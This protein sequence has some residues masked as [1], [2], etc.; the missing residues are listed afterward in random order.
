MTIQ[1]PAT[2]NETYFNQDYKLWPIWLGLVWW[3]AS[4]APLIV[5]AFRD[6]WWLNGGTRFAWGI[7]RWGVGTVF[8][9][10]G[11]WWLVAYIK[12][13]GRK[14]SKYYYR[15]IAWGIPFTWLFHLMAT[16]GWFIGGFQDGGCIGWNIF[17]WLFTTIMIG[18]L[19]FL[20][21]WL[22]KDR[23][24]KFYKWNEQEWWN[25]NHDEQPDTWPKQLGDFVDY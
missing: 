1:D 4:F 23:V 16:L 17:S 3:F 11:I 5:F 13:E 25:F 19:E 24:V 12:D 6:S 22:T 18:G 15:A 21:W 10:L 14:I 8:W 20:A 9:V 7:E 2:W